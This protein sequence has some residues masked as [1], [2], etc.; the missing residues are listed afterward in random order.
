M[1]RKRNQRTS[2]VAR[3][4]WAA[5]GEGEPPAEGEGSRPARPAGGRD[6]V[7]VQ[8]VL[9]SGTRVEVDTRGPS[10]LTSPRTDGRPPP[11]PRR[12]RL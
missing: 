8:G 3:C 5:Q 12:A 6:A 1:V 9:T 7:V 10:P 2:V 4:C 11:S